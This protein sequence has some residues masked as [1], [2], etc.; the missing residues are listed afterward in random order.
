[1]EHLLERVWGVAQPLIVVENFLAAMVVGG[2]GVEKCTLRNV[3]QKA[4]DASG[5]SCHFVGW[6]LV[7]SSL[8]L[9]LRDYCLRE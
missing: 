4:A 9:F 2:G 7:L 5:K 3:A 1:M 8:Q 6:H